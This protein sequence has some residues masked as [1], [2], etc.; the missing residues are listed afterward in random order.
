MFLNDSNGA[1]TLYIGFDCH[2]KNMNS[3]RELHENVNCISMLS[4][5]NLSFA[6]T[7]DSQSK[8]F[9]IQNPRYIYTVA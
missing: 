8:E 3:F 9:C 5:V 6:K 4:F 7:R 2:C 1:Y